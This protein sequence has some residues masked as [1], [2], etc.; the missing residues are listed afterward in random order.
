MVSDQSVLQAIRRKELEV[1]VRIE[2]ARS[3]ANT[4]LEEAQN[5]AAAILQRYD[6]EGEEEGKKFFEQEL[7]AIDKEIAR[8]E[9]Q[10]KEEEE[11]IRQKFEKKVPE[12]VDTV[13]RYIGFG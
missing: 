13:V 6:A 9:E 2:E 4:I 11:H 3:A 12:A 10:K 7:E 8:L 5:E 1:N